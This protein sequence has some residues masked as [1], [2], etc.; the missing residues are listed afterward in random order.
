M[1]CLCAISC[2]AVK[3]KKQSSSVPVTPVK[4]SSLVNT[5]HLD[6]LYTPLTFSTGTKTAGIF[7]YA[8]APDYHLVGDANEGFTCVDDVARAAQVYLRS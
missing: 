2:M 3:C 1:L 6:Y 8:E 4:D 5:S 7:I